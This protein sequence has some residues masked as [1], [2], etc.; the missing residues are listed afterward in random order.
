MDMMKDLLR[1][2]LD[3]LFLVFLDNILI[4]S[5]NIREHVGYLREV[6]QRLREHQLY[7]KTSMCE[8]VKQLVEFLGQKINGGG[9]TR[10]EEN[11]KA[12]RDGTTPSNVKGVRPFL[13][14][15]NYYR[16]FLKNFIIIANH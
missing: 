16:R 6:P 14:F 12:V 4:Y 13:G 11:L 8:W 2:F 3:Q 7:A 9:V 10:A 15:A 1:N 5:E